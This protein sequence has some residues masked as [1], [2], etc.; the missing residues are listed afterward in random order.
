VYYRTRG[1]R[2]FGGKLGRIQITG[3][4]TGAEIEKL[5]D[6][7]LAARLEV[8]AAAAPIP[9]LAAR[10]TQTPTLSLASFATLD[11]ATAISAFA[12]SLAAAVSPQS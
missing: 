4:L 10:Q 3:L 12:G 1:G 11:H 9:W 5:S 2:I 6:E 7:A 8:C